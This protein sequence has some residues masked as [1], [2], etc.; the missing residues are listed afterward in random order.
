MDQIKEFLDVNDVKR[1]LT[2]DTANAKRHLET[3]W[4]AKAVFNTWLAA[5]KGEIELPGGS[6]DCFTGGGTEFNGCTVSE[7]KE[8][9]LGNF[10]TTEFLKAAPKF[11]KIEKLFSEKAEMIA[12][13]R[14]RRLSEHDGEIDFDR[15]WEL[16]PYWNTVKERSGVAPVLDIWCEFAFN[17]G[18]EQSDITK[19]GVFC[20]A[21]ANA[22]ENAGIQ[23]NLN[24][25]NHGTARPYK[26][27]NSTDRHV[28]TVK[29]AGE[30]VDMQNLARCFT[31]GFYRRGMF[32]A[33][34]L[35]AWGEQGS[36]LGE[37]FGRSIQKTR[38]KANGEVCLSI[39][40]SQKFDPD[41]TCKA[42]LEALGVKQL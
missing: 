13:K 8:S 21:I 4:D 17:S 36:R 33:C 3:T 32:T 6:E 18:V 16:T 7:F 29:R 15:R 39:N 25:Y 20:W 31:S 40:D 37:G 28:V 42:I 14:K 24:L 10:D 23:V 19:F 5:N 11:A 27:S 22:I 34:Y 2:I 9:A 38:P 35:T 30:Y 26:W 1:V 41:A 12:P